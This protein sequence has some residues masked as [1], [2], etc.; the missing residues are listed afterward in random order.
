[1]LH[2]EP[3]QQV[4]LDE[5]LRF[6]ERYLAIEQVRFSDRLRVR[7]AVDDA[8][9]DALVPEFV[10]QPLVENAVRHGVARRAD[11]GTIEI[12]ARAEGDTLLLG[13]RDDGPGYDPHT[14][15][16]GVGLANVRTRLETLFGDAAHLNI[17]RAEG[18]GTRATVR[19]P[20]RRPEGGT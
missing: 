16:T 13:V 7:W 4:A 12:S 15:G 19:L 20:L 1:V 5:E 9:R 17:D 18:G 10:L 6:L 14:A 8:V 11:V 3:R 2:G